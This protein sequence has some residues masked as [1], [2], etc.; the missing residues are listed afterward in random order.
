MLFTS[1]VVTVPEGITDSSD[2]CTLREELASAAA[3]HPS[4]RR[5]PGAE[6]LACPARSDRSS[7]SMPG[8]ATA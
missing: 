1:V 6:M 3:W 4:G 7:R 5:A 8:V 2:S